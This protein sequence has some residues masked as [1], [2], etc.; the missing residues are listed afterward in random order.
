[1]PTLYRVLSQLNSNTACLE[2]GLGRDTWPGIRLKSVNMDS[3]G[4][5]L[6]LDGGNGNHPVLPCLENAMTIFPVGYSPCGQEVSDT[7]E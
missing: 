6:C 7:T 3:K 2:L 5:G 4:T 1:M